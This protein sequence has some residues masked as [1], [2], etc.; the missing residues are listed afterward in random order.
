VEPP[1]GQSPILVDDGVLA[2]V[3]AQQDQSRI[4]ADLVALSAAGGSTGGQV[5]ALLDSLSR[6]DALSGTEEYSVTSQLTPI[7]GRPPELALDYYDLADGQLQQNLLPKVNSL[8]A[9]G[10][11]QVAQDRDAARQQ[12][13]LGALLLGLVGLLAVGLLVWWQFDLVRRYRRVFNPPLLLATASVLAVALAGVV[14]LLGTASEVAGAVSQGYSPYATT[15][16][17][18][19]E[20]AGAEASESRWLVDGAYRPMLQ[21]QYT[22]LTR[23]LEGQLTT[24]SGDPGVIRTLRAY[25]AADTQLRSLADQGALD[26]AA[27]QLTGVTRGEVAFA[28]YDFSTQL[29]RLAQQQ[30]ALTADHF[31]AASDDLSGWTALPSVFLGIALLL[32][33]AG[34]RP[35]LAEFA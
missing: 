11:Q 16:Q 5:Q 3:T 21:Q 25:L 27:V 2:E 7:V 1:P 17:A 31:D 22:G 34:V 33:L 13:R 28:Y 9:A 26:Q 19:V 4:S 6:Y 10:E 29:D 23:T 30:L 18:Q 15:A 35:R 8:L 12:A 14:A 20:A 24:P 32:T